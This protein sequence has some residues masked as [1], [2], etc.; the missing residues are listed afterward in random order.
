[1]PPGFAEVDLALLGRAIDTTLLS[2]ELNGALVVSFRRDF[3]EKV[4]PELC[5]RLERARRLGAEGRAKE[6]GTVYQGLLL[7]SQV[8]HL[9]VAMM[10]MAHE[11]D[12]AGQPSTEIN[13]IL[14]SF[15]TDLQPLLDAGMSEDPAT[16]VHAT[17]VGAPIFARWIA[18]VDR[19]NSQVSSAAK[20][21]KIAKLVWDTAMLVVAAHDAARGLA[22]LA[23]AARPPMPPFATAL[24][25]GGV[26][27]FRGADQVRLAEA[28]R[29]LIA[30]GALD[31]AVVAGLS[32]MMGAEAGP[33][34]VRVQADGE[35]SISD[36]TGY[37]S[38]LPRPKGPFKILKGAEY[39]AAREAANRTNAAFR[40]A[41][42]A[43]YAGKQI[44]EIHPVKFNGSPT[45]LGNK[46]A[47]APPEHA[48]YTTFW[49]RLLKELESWESRR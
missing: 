11:A 12:A 40:A 28:L 47:L 34:P 31:A 19:W 6:A 5:G 13:Q 35:F 2:R 42:P 37:P 32:K 21:V 26:L 16:L 22:T 49:N 30:S 45:D 7:S 24:A 43:Q 23:A 36:W 48:Q 46:A 39:E 18:Y 4:L 44:H 33:S 9:T 1:M 25:G 3:A 17:E 41:D 27:V 15:A 38:G 10:L 8:M 20:Q 29:K 14:F